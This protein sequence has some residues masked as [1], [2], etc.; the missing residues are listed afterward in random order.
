MARV[1]ELTFNHTFNSQ[2]IQGIVIYFM[3]QRQLH[4]YCTHLCGTQGNQ[5]FVIVCGYLDEVQDEA[6]CIVQRKG[7]VPI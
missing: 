1:H 4:S 3:S 6:N 5:C 7:D 2:D